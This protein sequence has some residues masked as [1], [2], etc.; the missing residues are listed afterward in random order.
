MQRSSPAPG[1][2]D[3]RCINYQY[4]NGMWNDEVCFD[5][6]TVLCEWDG[7]EPLGWRPY[8]DRDEN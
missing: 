6:D 2:G 4:Q 1:T 8:R 7:V 5:L 3:E